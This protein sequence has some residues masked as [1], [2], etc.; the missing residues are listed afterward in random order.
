MITLFFFLIMGHN[1]YFSLFPVLFF[2][3]MLR[4]MSV[5]LFV[6]GFCYIPVNGI[7]LYSES[8]LSFLKLV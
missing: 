5:M 4:I 1:L 6:D 2:N 7:G 3:W 8:Q